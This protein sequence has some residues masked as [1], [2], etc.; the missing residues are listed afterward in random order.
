M[1]VAITGGTGFI[2]GWLLRALDTSMNVT[3]LGRE[4]RRKKVVVDD[5]EFKYI[6]T[7]YSESDL[8]K[9]LKG[10]EVLIHLAATRV[11]SSSFEPYLENIAISQ[12]LFEACNQNN[13]ANVV[14]LSS[15]SV[16]SDRNTLP[17]QEDEYVAPLSFY[18]ISKVSMENLAEYYN[19]TQA[20][21]IK[22]LR[23]AQVVGYGERKGFMLMNF[24]NQAF[25]NET[26][27]VYGEGAGKREYIYVKD[28]VEAILHSVQQPDIKGVFNIG[29]GA[30]TS[31]HELAK[32]I[33]SVFNNENNL[34]FVRGIKEDKT[35]L[36]MDNQK[37]KQQLG[38][39]P[40]W[41]LGAA[42]E[43][44]REIMVREKY[45]RGDGYD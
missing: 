22:S 31:H 13:I 27:K 39:E 6:Y 42:L 34:E 33:N 11:G 17:W 21:K 1:R 36:L 44:I 30:N 16:Y 28:I 38:W 37:A 23:V 45:E 2:G 10:S 40:K 5:K 32:M 4:K 26:L 43:D 20:M 35:I 8:V 18:G 19:L 9:K 3:V 41:S 14:C 15:I 7:D 25:N 29:T 12:S 24:I